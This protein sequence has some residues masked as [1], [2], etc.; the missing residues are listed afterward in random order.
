MF[1]FESDLENP[2]FRTH[3]DPETD[4]QITSVL[5]LII[6]SIAIQELY[7]DLGSRGGPM[8]QSS[9]RTTQ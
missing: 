6:N 4:P 5:E 9:T 3:K 7:L 1:T 2:V 8:V